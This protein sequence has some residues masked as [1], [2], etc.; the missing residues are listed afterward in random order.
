MVWIVLRSLESLNASTAPLT[1][2]LPADCGLTLAFPLSGGLLVK[3]TLAKLRIEAG[4]LHLPLESTKGPLEALI[5][6]NRYFQEATTPLR[7]LG[8]K[9]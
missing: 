9:T 2:T 7:R 1:T 5:V 6:L 3:A 8:C 4:P